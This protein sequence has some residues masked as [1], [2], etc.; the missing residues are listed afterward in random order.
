MAPAA[1]AMEGAL[2]PI[3]CFG[4]AAALCALGSACAPTAT[5]PQLT[6]FEKTRTYAK[7]KDQAWAAVLAYFTRNNISVKV[8]EK[9]SGVIYAENASF[10]TDL[11]D[12]GQSR[13]LEISRLASLNVF[14]RPTGGGTEVS[15]NTKFSLVRTMEGQTWNVE[16][17]SRGI[18]ERE[19]LD[20]I[21]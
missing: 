20:S 12:C 2:H 7:P 18:L 9:D 13:A 8:L 17:F 4:L 10:A 19:I 15:V 16:C 21:A 5:A 1:P 3:A 14:V 6:V 11:A